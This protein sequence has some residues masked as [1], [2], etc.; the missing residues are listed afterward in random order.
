MRVVFFGNSA[1]SY[2]NR[3]YQGFLEAECQLVAVV[4]SPSHRRGATTTAA[5]AATHQDFVVQARQRGMPVYDPPTPNQPDLLAALRA[6]E[7]DLLVAV[8]YMGIFKAD[9]LA[10]PRLWAVNFHAS[11]LPAYRGKHPVFWALRNGERWSG[12]TVHVVDA[13]LDTGDMLYQVRVRTR[14]NDT[15]ADLYDRIYERTADLPARLVRDAALGRLR[16]RPQ[17]TD[18]VS[19]YG[20]VTEADFRLNW[21]WPAERLRRMIRVSPGQCF[22]SVNG[23]RLYCLDAELAGGDITQLPG[24]LLSVGRTGGGVIQ[25]ADGA[26]R[27][28]RLRLDNGTSV[29]L[30]DACRQLGLS[31][32][33]ALESVA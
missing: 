8:G 23:R 13:G 15:P 12:L 19:Y 9:L 3:Y 18:G 20:S 17:P 11:L 7:P 21:S 1:S 24:T 30:A 26:L 29:S 4:D 32:G 10:I 33:A 22:T 5:A 28:H 27:V 14:R 16:P 31:I 2:S 25:A 6:L